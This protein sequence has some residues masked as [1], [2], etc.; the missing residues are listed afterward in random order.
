MDSSHQ[1]P[2]TNYQSLFTI[3]FCSR[4]LSIFELQALVPVNPIDSSHLIPTDQVARHAKNE[5]ASSSNMPK[6]P[7]TPITINSP[8]WHRC[9]ANQ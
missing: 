4:L 8:S 9:S 6:V 1:S 3:L 5:H 7:T 2:F